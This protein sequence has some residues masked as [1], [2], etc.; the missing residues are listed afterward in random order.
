[1]RMFGAAFFVPA[2][3]RWIMHR[4]TSDSTSGNAEGAS[5]LFLALQPDADTR[6]AL[7]QTAAAAGMA[8]ERGFRRVNPRRYHATLHFLGSHPAPP[9]GLVAGAERVAASLPG[10]A[11]DWTLDRLRSFD[12]RQPPRV[13]CG[14]VL[15]EALRRLW[16]QWHDRL[17]QEV[18][19]LRL[20]RRFVPHVTLAYGGAML[21]EV[22]VAPLR[23][24]VRELALLE[25]R[26][27]ERDYR[28]L[29]SWPLRQ[30]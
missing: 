27:G 3:H 29:A 18:P 11:F 6:L 30:D 20:E 13:L 21:P 12:G 22:A 26:T 23:W 7:A 15:P 5:K 9:L 8:P 16:R 4:S 10:G 14:R 28:Q 25:S 19:G 2:T 1:M 17:L 24:P